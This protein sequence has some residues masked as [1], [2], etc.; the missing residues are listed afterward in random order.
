MSRTADKPRE[1]EVDPVGVNYAEP[2]MRQYK[3][4]GHSFTA[5]DVRYSDAL[6][7]FGQNYSVEDGFKWLIEY[8]EKNHYSAAD[9]ELARRADATCFSMTTC[10]QA[11]LILNKCLLPLDSLVRLEDKIL[12]GLQICATKKVARSEAIK[13]SGRPS[14]QD[15]IAEQA[16]NY[17]GDL[18]IQVDK[19]LLEK[20]NDFSAYNYFV[21]KEVSAQ[22]ARYVKEYFLKCQYPEVFAAV[23]GDAENRQ[24]YSSLTDVELTKYGQFIKKIIDDC[25]RWQNNKKATR[26]PRAKKVKPV[27]AQLAKL[28]YQKEFVDL[29]IMS[30]NP[31]Q[32]I[33]ANSLWLYNTKDRK[34]AV[35]TARTHEGFSIKGTTLRD[36]NESLSVQKK[37][38]KPEVVLNRLLSGGKVVLKH[39]MEEIKAVE[40]KATGR[41]NGF[42]IILKAVK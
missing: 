5:S 17:T 7:Y 16:R 3:V 31:E 36:F 4:F 26:K 32:I 25:E 14:V 20:D 42:T 30:I 23:M 21:E 34:L 15:Y 1:K 27:S 10:T 33:G 6:R 38:R 11:K 40:Q 41:I 18:A 24:G 22:A 19:F 39:L 37:V 2:V 28:K 29:K 12:K 8:M 13:A 35:Y 9:I